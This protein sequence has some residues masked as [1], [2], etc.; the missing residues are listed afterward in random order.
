MSNLCAGEVNLL[1][2]FVAGRGYRHDFS[3]VPIWL[4]ETCDLRKIRSIFELHALR[5]LLT[6][7][8]WSIQR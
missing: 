7:N 5:N 1:A 8:P 6:L 2:A 3:V 4:E